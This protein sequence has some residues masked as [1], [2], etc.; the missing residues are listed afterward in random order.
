MLAHN[1]LKSHLVNTN[2]DGVRMGGLHESSQSEPDRLPIWQGEKV[3]SSDPEGLGVPRSSYTHHVGATAGKS[4]C[5]Q[6]SPQESP[7][8]SGVGPAQIIVRPDTAQHTTTDTC[9]D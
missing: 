1:G 2:L 6:G 5:T 4:T 7:K 3:A 9:A 8:C